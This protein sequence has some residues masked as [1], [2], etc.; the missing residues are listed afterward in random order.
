MNQTELKKKILSEY[1]DKVKEAVERLCQAP[2]IEWF[3]YGEGG[4]CRH[5]VLPICSDGSD[6]SYFE[7]KQ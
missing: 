5:G 7:K 3:A 6:C 4:S 2:C 1:G